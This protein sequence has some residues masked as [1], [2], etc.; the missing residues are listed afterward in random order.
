MNNMDQTA[1]EQEEQTENYT[2]TGEIVTFKVL[3]E[4]RWMCLILAVCLTS[5]PGAAGKTACSSPFSIPARA[6]GAA[7]RMRS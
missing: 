3:G 5:G 6:H 2:L 1:F 4:R 7:T